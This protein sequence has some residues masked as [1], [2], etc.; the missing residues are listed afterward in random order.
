MLLEIVFRTYFFIG[1]HTWQWLSERFK[2][3][4]SRLLSAQVSQHVLVAV[5]N[6]CKPG[7]AAVW[8]SRFRIVLTVDERQCFGHAHVAAMHGS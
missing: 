1:A 6:V 8:H 2:D 4:F 3:P 7:T 5:I